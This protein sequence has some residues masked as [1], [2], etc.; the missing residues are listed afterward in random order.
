MILVVVCKSRVPGPRIARRT[1]K[2]GERWFRFFLDWLAAF[3]RPLPVV[4]LNLEKH[5]HD[6]RKNETRYDEE[7]LRRRGPDMLQCGFVGGQTV[8]DGENA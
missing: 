6:P 5:G 3:E 8:A 7:R 4:L 1:A 2:T